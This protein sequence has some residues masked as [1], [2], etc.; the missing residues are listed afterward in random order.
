MTT[1][2]R[3]RKFSGYTQS[4]LARFLGISLQSYWKKENGKVPFSDEEKIKVRDIL[5]KHD[6]SLTIEKLFF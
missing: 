1:V 6:S 4:D 5:G 2:K 3:Y